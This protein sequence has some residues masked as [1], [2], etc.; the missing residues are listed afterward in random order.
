MGSEKRKNT[1]LRKSMKALSCCACG[2]RGTDWNPVDPCHVRTFKVTQSDDPANIIPMCRSCHTTQHRD[3]W[4]LFLK[5]NHHVG[6]LLEEKGWEFS[7]HPF[8]PGK[9]IMTHKDIK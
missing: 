3:G 2:S 9:L 5:N 6:L 8:Q 7:T 1:I 4:D